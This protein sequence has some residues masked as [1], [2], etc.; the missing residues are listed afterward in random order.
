MFVFINYKQ[1]VEPDHGLAR[2]MEDALA[3]S[4]HQVFRDESVLRGGDIWTK[5]LLQNIRKCNALISLVSN[6]SM[7]SPWVLN[8]IDEA[9]ELKKHLIPVM[10][11][12]L[13][14]EVN[15]T[16]YR[17]KFADRQY[18]FYR[19]DKEALLQSVLR[20]LE[21]GPK[22][23]YQDLIAKEQTRSGI[24]N[25][26][27][28]ICALL[29]FLKEDHVNAVAMGRVD[30][31]DGLEGMTW[32]IN[33]S[34]AESIGHYAKVIAAMHLHNSEI[35][36]KN[37]D[38]RA[39]ENLRTS[40]ERIRCLANIVLTALE[41]WEPE[42]EETRKAV[43]KTLRR[44]EGKGEKGGFVFRSPNDLSVQKEP[45]DNSAEPHG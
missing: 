28:I 24:H 30:Y 22:Y 40:G 33:R 23:L 20:A 42:V 38:K 18:L 19:G 7:R 35:M 14:D 4:G 39:S 10:L 25:P 29:W 15:F 26:E 8:E 27:E 9:I 11:E 34:L 45:D 32:R 2:F 13:E 6:A 37:G 12:P 31:H 3:S 44:I 21:A 1:G 17:P 41:Q 43:E 36:L 5:K 16:S